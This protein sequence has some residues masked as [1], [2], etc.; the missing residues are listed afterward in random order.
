MNYEF[1]EWY[2]VARPFYQV[3]PQEPKVDA[4]VQL[5]AKATEELLLTQLKAPAQVLV[6]D[7]AIQK[8]ICHEYLLF[9]RFLIGGGWGEV[10][11]VVFNVIPERLHL[12]DMSQRYVSRKQRSESRG[13]LIP[14]AAV[15]FI[16]GKDPVFSSV[17]VSSPAG[18]ILAVAHEVLLSASDEAQ[19]N[20][21]LAITRAFLDLICCLMLGR[22]AGDA[23]S[24]AAEQTLELRTREYIM[25]HLDSHEL[26]VQ[27]LSRA[28]GVSR[29]TVYR[30]FAD[31]GGIG[32]YIRNR[33]L[34]RCFF[35]LAGRKPTRGCI[36]AVSGRW[37]FH[38]PSHFNR[39]FRA[40]F[41]MSPS[42]CMATSAASRALPT[43]NVTRLSR[44]WLDQIKRG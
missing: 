34:D 33:R 25:S 17:D 38:D 19:G 27:T 21:R 40:R 9:E 36:K 1:E 42:D 20:S 16:P 37:N 13:V 18:R 4:G 10:G 24:V 15:G 29:A 14:H 11:D 5:K 7:P 43:V 31:E 22:H 41:G 12:I 32:R 8:G 44:T 23:P 39:L 26:G 6:H 35:E 30:Q 3:L 28:F 2:E